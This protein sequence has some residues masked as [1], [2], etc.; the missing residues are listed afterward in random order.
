MDA[1]AA[2]DT[3]S[4]MLRDSPLPDTERGSVML[5]KEGEGEK[6]PEGGAEKPL[7]ETTIGMLVMPLFQFPFSLVLLVFVTQFFL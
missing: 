3:V 4:S 7:E 1:R 2:E 5:P 6:L